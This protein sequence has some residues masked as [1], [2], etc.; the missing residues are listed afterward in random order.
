MYG[1]TVSPTRQAFLPLML[2]LGESGKNHRTRI[3]SK[4]T[5]PRG[6]TLG[7][8]ASLGEIRGS[9]QGALLPRKIAG[10]QK[11]PNPS[12]IGPKRFF[13]SRA[14]DR[15]PPRPGHPKPITREI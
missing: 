12:A 10:T 13:S 7:A 8:L 15:W 6:S 1:S 9:T 14:V 11:S 4:H 2:L 5:S 3:T